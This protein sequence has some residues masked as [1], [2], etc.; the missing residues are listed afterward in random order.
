MNSD[1]TMGETTHSCQLF[2]SF[3]YF[4]TCYCLGSI[5]EWE[6]IF[7]ILKNHSS[8]R[9]NKSADVSNC[10]LER[11]PIELINLKKKNVFLAF[12]A[13]KT[14]KYEVQNTELFTLN[15]IEK[16]PSNLTGSFDRHTKSAELIQ[17]KLA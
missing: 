13:N 12:I 11:L 6:L 7:D 17:N 5:G 8:A 4:S 14:L 10:K 16:C 9:S 3:F 1:T 2:S 15:L